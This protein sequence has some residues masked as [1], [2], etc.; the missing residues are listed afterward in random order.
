MHIKDA[1]W[2]AEQKFARINAH[3]VKLRRVEG[4][5]KFFAVV[6]GRKGPFCAGNIKGHLAGMNFVG[7]FYTSAL[8]VIKYGVKFFSEELEGFFDLCLVGLGVPGN[9]IPNRRATKAGDDGD[10]HFLCGIC[11]KA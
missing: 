11:G 1:I 9:A 6:E 7:V 10:A 3:P 4:K 2:E 8:K 5:S